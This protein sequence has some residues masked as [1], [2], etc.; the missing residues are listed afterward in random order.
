M[1]RPEGSFSPGAGIAVVTI[2]WTALVLADRSHPT[3]ELLAELGFGR[4]PGPQ[5]AGA[6]PGTVL[7]QLGRQGFDVLP[8][9]GVVAWDSGT[10]RLLLRGGMV[11]E[12][13][14][15][16]DEAPALVD[17]AG[18]LTWTEHVLTD[19]TAVTLRLPPEGRSGEV[20]G[21]WTVGGVVAAGSIT[22]GPPAPNA[23]TPASGSPTGRA[24]QPPDEPS[25]E[26]SV[27]PSDDP[28]DSRA[29]QSE[30]DAAASSLPEPGPAAFPPPPP[31]ASP[32]SDVPPGSDPTGFDPGSEP[33]GDPDDGHT[34]VPP[35]DPGN[36]PGAASGDDDVQV[37]EP[38]SPPP[39]APPPSP[40]PPPGTPV[41]DVHTPADGPADP[42]DDGS[43]DHLF[44]S[45]IVKSVEGAAVRTD[46]PTGIGADVPAGPAERHQRDPIDHDGLTITVSELRRLRESDPVAPSGTPPPPPATA[47]ADGEHVTRQ[48]QGGHLNPPQATA[49]RVCGRPVDGETFRVDQIELGTFRFSSGR[50]V[51]VTGTILIGRSP[52]PAGG[53]SGPVEL[54]EVPSPRHDISRTHVEV[55]VEG[56]QVLVVDRGSTNGTVI[57]IPGRQPQRLRA[58][59][60][61]PL[62]VGGSVNLADEVEFVYEVST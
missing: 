31:P 6:T 19:A 45:T 36:E 27:E 47:S 46:T 2:N 53:H 1:T 44:G 50:N 33:G 9:L 39:F 51:P 3:V 55:R 60:P 28:S 24:D 17:S 10:C 26:P 35:T 25:V 59:E 43:Y 54:V 42:D 18:V 37:L 13:I 61:F 58:G 15:V 4:Y 8:P 38:P 48:C 11:A 29:D 62:P 32:I 14:D 30:V 40:P 49:C 23:A 21:F 7:E 16:P 41:T 57:T 34:L 12:V 5:Q 22:C 20:E 56:W 52:K